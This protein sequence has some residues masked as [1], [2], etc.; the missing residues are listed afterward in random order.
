[1]N[2]H[3]TED[4]AG[5]L[6]DREAQGVEAVCHE[7]NPLPLKCLRHSLRFGLCGEELKAHTFVQL[8]SVCSASNAITM[9]LTLN[10]ETSNTKVYKVSFL[11]Y[12]AGC[13][14]QCHPKSRFVKTLG[15]TS[16]HPYKTRE[17]IS[18]IKR[19]TKSVQPMAGDS[20]DVTY[21]DANA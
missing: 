13:G 4:V 8:P 1:L 7:K 10:F 12:S 19:A 16:D 3:D 9:Q 11:M 17:A 2:T 5:D 15:A 20:N 21:R 18:A 6:T 14:N